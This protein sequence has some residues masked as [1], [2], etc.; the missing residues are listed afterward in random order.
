MEEIHIDATA[1]DNGSDDD[2]DSDSPTPSSIS[3][4]RTV[5]YPIATTEIIENVCLSH[6]II[7]CIVCVCLLK[8]ILFLALY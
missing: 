8:M 1:V 6:V 7:I 4:Q 5:V 3:I 2:I